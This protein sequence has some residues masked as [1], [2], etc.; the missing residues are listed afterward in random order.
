MKPGPLLL[1]AA[2]VVAS[3]GFSAMA[4]QQPGTTAHVWRQSQKTDSRGTTFTRLTLAG[5]FLKA[6]PQGDLANRP[7]LVVDCVPPKESHKSKGK[8]ESA[9]LLVGTTLK[10]TLRAQSINL[11][12]HDDNKSEIVIKFDMPDSTAV[13]QACD[14]D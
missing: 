12:T 5:K 7:A 2:F 1:L 10:K 14:L 11:T 4:Q 8:F 6:P 13:K 9:S 3:F